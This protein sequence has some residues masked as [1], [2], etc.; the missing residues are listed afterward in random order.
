M[1]LTASQPRS[2]PNRLANLTQSAYSQIF[3]E[4]DR[5]EQIQ[6]EQEELAQRRLSVKAQERR[7]T[8][9]AINGIIGN[10]SQARQ[11]KDA[12]EF[13]ERRFNAEQSLR[14][15][16][17]AADA[18]LNERKFAADSALSFGR[19]GLARDE[20]GFD[21]RELESRSEIGSIN[22]SANLLR[23]QTDR[24]RLDQSNAG[25]EGIFSQ[26]GSNDTSL[27]ISSGEGSAVDA[28]L[29]PADVDGNPISSPRPDDLET[30]EQAEEVNLNEADQAL[31]TSLPTGVPTSDERSILEGN[32]IAMEDEIARSPMNGE[33]LGSDARSIKLL[34]QKT[35]LSGDQMLR[36]S[37]RINQMEVK[38]KQVDRVLKR[39]AEEPEGDDVFT[40]R[41]GQTEMTIED[42]A[43]FYDRNVT[44]V[45]DLSAEAREVN[46]AIAKNPGLGSKVAEYQDKNSQSSSTTTP[47]P[48]GVSTASGFLDLYKGSAGLK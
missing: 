46:I 1:L 9:G 31:S 32:R 48:T 38:I 4:L 42:L 44:N 6:I 2:D 21:N 8:V 34:S 45:K 23:A 22:A 43:K 14:E 40:L 30:P 5:R 39:K 20:L 13:A 16:K 33:K 28:S 11:A 3:R 17:F 25:L 10:L 37:R 35:G 7:A 15:R 27:P 47:A 19:L 18:S 29:F 26:F 12:Q 36:E 24:D 41:V